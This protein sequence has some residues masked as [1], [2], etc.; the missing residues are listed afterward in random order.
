MYIQAH[1]GASG[2]APENTMAAFR[3]GMESGVD[4]LELDVR[5]TKDKVPVVCHD[6]H[7]NRVSNGGKQFVSDLTYEELSTYD[8]GAWYSDAFKGERIPLLEDV[9]KE[10]EKSHIDL[11]IELKHGPIIGDGL[12]NKVLDLVHQ[13][14]MENRS[15]YS[16][17]DHH[18][19][20]RLYRLD[21]SARIGLIFHVNIVNLF[22]Y[23][24]TCGMDVFS[25]HP[26]FFY[27][28][29]D[30]IKQAHDLG[31][32]VNVYTLDDPKWVEKY[33]KMGV[34][35]LITNKLLHYGK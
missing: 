8:F 4:C 28:T 14:N 5:L 27:I 35:G 9:L 16:A 7:I 25:I 15:M 10:A 21:N 12:E 26:N 17:F 20:Q 6:A 29:D 23:I 18:T 2:L 33:D 34:D 24:K 1:R 31:I 13:Y 22:D 3:K 19:L 32:K 30:M 11:N